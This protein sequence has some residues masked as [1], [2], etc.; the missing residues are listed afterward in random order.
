[1]DA[2]HKPRERKNSKKKI[3]NIADPPA[4]TKDWG[5]TP[6]NPESQIIAQSQIGKAEEKAC[7]SVCTVC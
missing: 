7:C 1:M 2:P 6:P 4:A 3:V 5:V